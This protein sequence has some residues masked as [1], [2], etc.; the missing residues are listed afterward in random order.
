[1]SRTG[2]K[3]YT[4]AN[5][6]QTFE[7]TKAPN[8]C[9]NCGSA[10]MGAN[11]KTVA[12]AKAQIAKLQ[13]IAPKAEAA[14]AEYVTLR[15]Q[16]DQIRMILSPYATRGII[17]REEIPNIKKIKLSAALAARREELREQEEK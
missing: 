8:F 5:C 6:G 1:M 12:Y 17:K 16:Y 14:W 13:E 3:R 4:C 2:Y 15:A 11:P 7:L 10:N 9:Q